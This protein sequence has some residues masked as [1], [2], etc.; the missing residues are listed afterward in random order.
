MTNARTDLGLNKASHAAAVSAP[1]QRLHHTILTAYARTGRPPARTDLVPADAIAELANADLI[2][3]DG[4]G[5]LT[6]AYPFSTAPTAHHLTLADGTRAY[7]MCAID[8]LGVS[9][10]LGQP[11][12]I[13]STDALTQAAIGIRVD[14]DRAD[15]DPA[16]TVVYAGN[17]GDCCATSAERTCG[18]LNFFGSEESARQWAANHPDLTGTVLSQADAVGCG[19]AEFGT[20]LQSLE[21]F[22]R[23]WLD[24]IERI[25]FA[26]FAIGLAGLTRLGERP[27]RLDQLARILQLSTAQTATLVRENTIA[28]I[29][30]G[31]IHW[32]DPF[33]GPQ[34]LRTLHIGDRTVSMNS[35]CAPDLFVI[36]A[37]LDTPFRVEDTCAATGVPIQVDFVP[38]GYDRVTP[39]ETGTVLMPIDRLREAEGRN[40]AQINDII[41]GYQPF[42]ASAGA[43]RGWLADHPGGRFFTVRE[44]FERSWVRHYGETLRPLIHGSD[45]QQ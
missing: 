1:A 6:A 19:I 33:P 38:G 34:P 37:V 14:G 23:A 28:R 4:A 13:T 42:F 26:A 7:A 8:A 40:F 39:A 5:E 29:D 18:Y 25:P 24:A 41:C 45:I 9:A 36:A 43:A 44:M 30:D 20:L 12:A 15:W 2:V 16:T 32:D 3:L 10:M 31:M 27:A 11:V 35:G 17:T 22:D 21:Q